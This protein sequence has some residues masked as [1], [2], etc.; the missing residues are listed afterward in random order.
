MKK[1]TF[2]GSYNMNEDQ[3]FY[4]I[5]VFSHDA[6]VVFKDINKKLIRVFHNNFIQLAHFIKDKTLIGFNNYWYDDKIL[7]Y[8]LGLKS[9]K[10]IKELN[11]KII[12]GE[13]V[14][15]IGKPK[16]KSLD[17]FQQI[18]V[19]KPS[20][21]KIEGNYGK[22]ILESSV[23]FTINRPLTDEE[24]EDVLNYCIY[25]VDT[26]IDI[27]KERVK[28]YFQPKKY[29]V[30][31]LKKEDAIKWNTTTIS[32]NLLLQKPLPKWS[33][34]RI[35]EDF[36]DLVPEEVKEMWIEAAALPI[37][38]PFKGSKTIN[39]FGCEIQFAFGGLHGANKTIKRAKKVKLL[40]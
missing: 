29:L 20:L 6:F 38:S 24:Y 15:Y 9:A 40:D 1:K 25:D 3:L 14:T 13:N 19:S 22:M 21:K 28:S 7:T 12:S 30:E 16:F 32:A 2:K 34:L 23:P 37:G 36:L 33:G 17:V 11:D 39:D 10:Q 4:D 18:D 35:E 8:M 5:E 31:M 27:Y 26:T